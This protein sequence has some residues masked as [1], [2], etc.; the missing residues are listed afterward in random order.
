MVGT[1]VVYPDRSVSPSRRVFIGG[2]D[3]TL[4]A[5][6]SLEHRSR[7]LEGGLFQT[8]SARPRARTAAS[9]PIQVPPVLSTDENG[10]LIIN[11]ATGD[12]EHR[13]ERHPRTSSA[14][15]PRR[16][17]QPR[18]R[19]RSCSGTKLQQIWRVT[20]PM[21]VFDKTLYFATY[22]PERGGTTWPRATAR[23]RL[24]LGHELHHAE[25]RR[26]RRR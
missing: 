16:A 13:R 26:G 11:A 4:L 15:P 1:P 22:V 6:R 5:H 7:R 19:R 14:R 23:R 2:A 8:S 25:G 12:R 3:G 9:Q 17:R 20:G 21:T 24:A 10:G 18:P